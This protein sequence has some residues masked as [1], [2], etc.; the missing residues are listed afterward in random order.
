M[1]FAK[2][3]NVF[4]CSEGLSQT[5]VRNFDVRRGGV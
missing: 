5:V 4:L 2:P 3:G 1:V